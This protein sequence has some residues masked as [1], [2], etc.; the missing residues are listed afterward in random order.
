MQIPNMVHIAIQKMI[1]ATGNMVAP[2]WFQIAGVV[3]NFVLNPILIFGVGI[4]PSMGIRGS[5]VATVAGYSLSMILAFALLL[6]KKQKVQIKIKGF[7][8]QKQMIRRYFCL[9]PAI[10]YYERPQFVYGDV[11][12][13]VSGGVF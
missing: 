13:S 9:W 11:R 4:F 8:L 7:H 2:M 3:V 1:Q 12:Q 5:A 10:F 6:D